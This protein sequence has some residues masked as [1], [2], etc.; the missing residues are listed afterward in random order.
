MTSRFPVRVLA[1]NP[2][3]FTLEGTN[4]W[5]VGRTPS[6][7]ID[8][9]PDDA[10]HLR[11]VASSAGPIAAILLTHQHPDH[12]PGAAGLARLT[13]APVRSFGA[14]SAERPIRDGEVFVGGDVRLEAIH[15]PGHTSDHVAFRD[16]AASILFTGD[17]VLGR[18]TSVIDPPDGDLTDYLASLH[19]MLDLA[20]AVICPGHGPTVWHAEAKLLE[21][22][23]HRMERER[24]VLA[25]LQE[26]PRSAADMVPGIYSAYP[27]ELYPAAARS[28]LAHLLKLERERRAFRLDGEGMD[29]PDQ[30]FG[31]PDHEPHDVDEETT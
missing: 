2:G 31:L 30:R 17:A 29:G 24:Q 11:E 19:R 26:G 10:G 22:I 9:G 16:A 5:I 14:P 18:G 6:L 21:Y 27:E 12:A 25:A 7:V 23:D 20:P 4:T 8:P 13:G 3:P 15:T 28:L 1:P